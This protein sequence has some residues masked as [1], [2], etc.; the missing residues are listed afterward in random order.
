MTKQYEK[1]LATLEGGIKLHF[2]KALQAIDQD[3]FEGFDVKKLVW[4]EDLYRIRI[5]K[6]RIIFRKE[7]SGNKVLKI[8][9]RWDVYK[10]I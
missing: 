6:W 10:W 3:R 9:S 7:S 8:E 1:F 4:F 5:G 2:F